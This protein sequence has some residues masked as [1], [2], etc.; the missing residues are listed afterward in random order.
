L[1]AGNKLIIEEEKKMAKEEKTKEDLEF[2]IHWEESE[3]KKLLIC[4]AVCCGLGIIIGVI[5]GIIQSNMENIFFGLWFGT[6]AGGVISYITGIPSVFKQAVKEHGF[7]EGL[8]T[9]LLGILL[10]VFIFAI[11]GPVIL[12]IRVLIMN[13][14]IKKFKK[15]LSELG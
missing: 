1:K 7:L 8:K 14:K 3:K 9:T 13:Y 6:G 4:T 15:L 2:D 5:T 11:L 12:L 10:W